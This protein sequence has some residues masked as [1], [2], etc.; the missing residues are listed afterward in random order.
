MFA[1]RHENILADD[2]LNVLMIIIGKN[3]CVLK[4][5]YRIS[6]LHV[7]TETVPETWCG[8]SLIGLEASK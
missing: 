6:S 8:R 1:L 4:R 2:N 3:G 5:V 7:I